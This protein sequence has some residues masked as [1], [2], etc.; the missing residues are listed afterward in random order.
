VRPE[1]VR[2]RPGRGGVVTAADRDGAVVRLRVRGD[3]GAE[4][5]AVAV[6]VEVPSVGDNVAVDVDPD[7]VVEVRVWRTEDEGRV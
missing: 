1:A 2:V 6:G 5:E 7:G 3:D 4:L